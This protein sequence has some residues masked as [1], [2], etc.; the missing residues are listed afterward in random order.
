MTSCSPGEHAADP[1]L[2]AAFVFRDRNGGRVSSFFFFFKSVSLCKVEAFNIWHVVVKR[3]TWYPCW[4]MT[5]AVVWGGW[6]I[7]ELAWNEMWNKSSSLVPRSPVQIYAH[8][9]VSRTQKRPVLFRSIFLLLWE[10]YLFCISGP[11]NSMYLLI[12]QF[13]CLKW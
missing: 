13:R 8:H 6:S 10:A 3:T 11:K 1:V 5:V 4:Q 2:T 7:W 12:G 9:C